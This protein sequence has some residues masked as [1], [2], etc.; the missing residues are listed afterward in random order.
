MHER[1]AASALGGESVRGHLHD[2]V[3]VFARQIAIGPG[4]AHDREQLV[5]GIVAA[6]GLGDDLLRQDVERRVVH[7]DA[8]EL[9]AAH[10][11]QE[12]RAFDE[13]IARDREDAAFRQSRDRVAGT[14]DALQQRGDAMRRADL[15]D[16][17][18]VADVDAQLQRRRGHERLQL[19]G[20][21]ARLG[22]EALLFGETAVMRG[23]RVLAEALAEMM[24]DPL[25]HLAR[26]HE[27][28]RGAVLLDQLD[29][30]IVVIAPD[31]VRH[32]RV[33]RRSRRLQREIHGPAMAF[34]DDRALVVGDEVL[35]HVFDRLLRRREPEA[36]QRPFGDLL[37]SLER[38][39]EMRAAAR[40]D[41]RVDLVD[42]DGADAC[43]ACPGCARR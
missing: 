9:A 16:Q 5:L 2:G 21:E 42:D 8:I 29:E 17:I 1:A 22:V 20:L 10:R 38:E 37:Q 35:R 34:V 28:E 13:V 40:A 18:D 3:E 33:E 11:A 14:A 31:L 32:H 26:V 36:Q 30:P 41:E 25:G 7:D 15:A 43:A 12:R 39:R 23:D 27:H 19:A 6:R 4:A 24:R